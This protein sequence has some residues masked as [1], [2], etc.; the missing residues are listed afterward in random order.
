MSM[1]ERWIQMDSKHPLGDLMSITMEKIHELVDVNTIIGQPITTPDG[2]TLIPVSKVSF[3]FASGGADFKNK[4]PNTQAPFGGGGTAGV[5]IAPIAFL[6]IKE[7]NVR[8]VGL[9]NTSNGAID[10]AIDMAPE[11]I[12]KLAAILK[13]DDTP[14]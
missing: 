13:K 4:Q 5:K 3:G 10:K 12:D 11:L 1:K 9:E 6:V 8:V 14:T 7:G 2:I